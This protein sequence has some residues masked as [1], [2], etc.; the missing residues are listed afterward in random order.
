MNEMIKSLME[1]KSVRAFTDREIT[2]HDR[3]LILRAAMEAPT[4]GNQ[5]MY[6]ILD[7]TDQKLKDTLAET[8][9]KPAIY[10][11]RKNGAYLLCR[12]SEMVQRLCGRRY[13]SQK[14]GS[15]RFSFGCTGRRHCSPKC[16]NSR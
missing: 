15:R 9:D 14:A 1:R 3:E 7:I 6:T 8:C 16:S 2:S 10:R 5:Q 4:A 13:K 11:K 12:L